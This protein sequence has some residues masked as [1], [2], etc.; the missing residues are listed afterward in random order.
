M[1]AEAVWAAIVSGALCGCVAYIA[2]TWP[3]RL[4][5]ELKHARADI[6]RL[7]K[8]ASAEQA[9]DLARFV[10]GRHERTR[11]VHVVPKPGDPQ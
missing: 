5:E 3:E 11:T 7:E 2:G 6:A 1:T 8:Q 9:A 10:A 4:R